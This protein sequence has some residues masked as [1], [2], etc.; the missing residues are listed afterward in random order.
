MAVGQR[1][2]RFVWIGVIVLAT[3][4]VAAATR[5]A[6]V[7]FW[8][9]IFAGK[10]P[11]AAAL[12]IGFAKHAALTQ[13]HII[14][15]ALFLVL[16]PLQFV[17]SIRMKHLQVHRWLGRI[18]VVSGAIIGASAL[19]MSYTTNIGGANETAATTLFGILFLFCLIKAYRHIRRKKSGAASRVDDSYIRHWPGSGHDQADCRDLLCVPQ[20]R[21]TRVLRHCILAWIHNHIPRCGGVDRLHSA[22]RPS[23]DAFS[24]ID[25]SLSA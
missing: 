14:P 9:G 25:G 2:T 13:I 4:G 11:P 1:A 16:T 17:P 21:T 7:L 24:G 23:D 8:P 12:D 5:R 20:T 22:T 6:M 10:F 15:A 19:V 18:L 3:I